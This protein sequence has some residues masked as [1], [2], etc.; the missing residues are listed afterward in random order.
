MIRSALPI[1]L[2]AQVPACA[3]ALVGGGPVA[4]LV[5]VVLA[6]LAALAASWRLGALGGAGPARAPAPPPPVEPA[7]PP[8][9]SDYVRR[10]RHD[11]RGALSPA[12]LTADRLASH[13]DPN[14]RRFGEVIAQSIERAAQLLETPA[15][16]KPD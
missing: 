8:E 2:L 14:A 4:C 16:N 11:L 1:L 7:V 13:P 10:L 3:V 15:A 9:S 12:M 5:A 6:V